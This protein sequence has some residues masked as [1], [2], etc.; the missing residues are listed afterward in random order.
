MSAMSP[1]SAHGPSGSSPPG[2]SGSAPPG[3]SDDD[4]LDTLRRLVAAV[5]PVPGDLLFTIG[6]AGLG[7]EVCELVS[8]SSGAPGSPVGAGVAG[9]FRGDEQTTRATFESPS[10]TIMLEWS[11]GPSGAVRLDGWLAP[12]SAC[13]IEIRTAEGLQ[14]VE[15]DEGGRFAVQRLH[16]GQVQLRVCSSSR[17]AD[18]FRT[19]VTPSFVL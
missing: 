7:V 9:G 12:P 18:A 8:M 15:T 11:P 4:L 17:Q 14:T 2:A 13:R 10:L 19:V 5:D 1:S 6:V 3:P 16:R